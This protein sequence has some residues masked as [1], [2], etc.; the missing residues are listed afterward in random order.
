MLLL[1]F[2]G[3]MRVINLEFNPGIYSDEGT[4]IE[5]AQNMMYGKTQYFS[6]NQ[7]ILLI[8]RMPLFSFLL[9]IFFKLF[10][11]GIL[12]LRIF[13]S[14]LGIFT[15]IVLYLILKSILGEGAGFIPIISV[16]LYSIYPS[17]IIYHR[18]GFSYNLLSIFVLLVFWGLWKYW[19]TENNYWIIF[20]SLCLGVG[21][22]VDLSGF[23]FFLFAALVI[24]IKNYRKFPLFLGFSLIPFVSYS[25]VMI[26]LHREAFGFDFQFIFNRVNNNFGKQTVF[27]LVNIYELINKDIWITFGLLGFFLSKNKRF[28]IYSFFFFLFSFIFS[29]R[30]SPMTGLS[31]YYFIPFFSIIIIGVSFFFQFFYIKTSVLLEYFFQKTIRAL[32]PWSKEF[33]RQHV[34]KLAR[35]L[36]AFTISLFLAPTLIFSLYKTLNELNGELNTSMT[37]FMVNYFDAKLASEYVNNQVKSEDLVV[38]SPAVAWMIE[39]NHVDFQISTSYNGYP[40][41][42]LPNNIPK[43]RF[44]FNSDYRIAKYIIID[45]LWTDYAIHDN[46]HIRNMYEEIVN[47]P[48]VWSWKKIKVYE[49]INY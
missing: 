10:G 6:I 18:L 21:T 16:F 43:N 36:S 27:L 32:N 1:F 12:Q 39:S 34:V 8:G 2:S 11:V 24:L 4:Q 7:S 37:S 35:Y 28:G 14:F 3:Y 49:N 46:I 5:I 19:K 13:A 29:A 41:I 20:T 45:N 15:I 48:L 23:S 26:L 44:Q 17:A 40:S 38:A 31:Y 22:L 9:S 42:H 33:K 47:W 30:H 25:L